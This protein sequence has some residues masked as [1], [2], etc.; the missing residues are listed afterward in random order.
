MTQMKNKIIYCGAFI[1]MNAY[2]S[3]LFFISCSNQKQE[4]AI[5]KTESNSRKNDRNKPPASYADTLIID[6]PAAVFYYPDSLQ[7][8]KIK[9]ITDS[10]ILDSAEHDCFFQMRNARMVLKKN[11]PTVKIIE[12]SKARYLQ[13]MKSDKNIIITDL[14]T[15]NDMCGIILFNGMKDPVLIDMMN[16]DSEWD[17]YFRK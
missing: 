10:M 17:Y 2:F 6:F 7:L 16:I 8:E 15:K 4:Q 13:F 14:D 9:A 3:L 5:S 1:L 11:L 12:T